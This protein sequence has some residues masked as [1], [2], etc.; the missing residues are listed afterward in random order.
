MGRMSDILDN[1]IRTQSDLHELWRALVQPLGWRRRELWSLVI[2]DDDEPVR[3][4]SQ[5][6]DLPGELDE[7]ASARLAMMM[8]ELLADFPGG[9]IALLWCR[10]GRGPSDTDRRT[11]ARL[12]AA[13]AAA[14][15]AT[16]V[17]HLAA[18][19]DIVPLPL[20]EVGAAI[21]A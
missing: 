21:S 6:V 11:T 7:T 13:L 4:I 15:V 14:Q 16:D 9:R 18:D 20:D 17:I 19:D 12:Y 2:D 3:Q 8:G 5:L 1:P 10:P